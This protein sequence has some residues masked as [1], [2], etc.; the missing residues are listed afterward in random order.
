VD[1]DGGGGWAGM[2]AGGSI[3][4]GWREENGGPTAGLGTP[5]FGAEMAY[6][7]GDLDME[8]SALRPSIIKSNI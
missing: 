1:F 3:A 2:V 4:A 8:K 6:G 5:R 7:S